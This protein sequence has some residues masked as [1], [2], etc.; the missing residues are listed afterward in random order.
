MNVFIL[1]PLVVSGNTRIY[2]RWVNNSVSA[3]HSI[4]ILVTRNRCVA[5]LCHKLIHD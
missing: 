4:V 2:R 1:G 3:E 5:E